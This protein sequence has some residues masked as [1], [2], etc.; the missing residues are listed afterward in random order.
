[1]ILGGFMHIP[2]TRLLDP[3]NKQLLK[4][5]LLQLTLENDC[6]GV[7]GSMKST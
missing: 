5:H 1:M 4:E 6:S 7:R 2:R 3:V